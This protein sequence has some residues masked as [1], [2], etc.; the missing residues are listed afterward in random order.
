MSVRARLKLPWSSPLLF[1]VIGHHSLSG[2]DTVEDSA[3]PLES[4]SC[5]DAEQDVPREFWP[6][7]RQQFSGVSGWTQLGVGC[8]DTA[9]VQKKFKKRKENGV[10]AVHIAYRLIY[11]Q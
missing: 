9:K 10:V 3:F 7:L 11:V 4:I 6:S 1:F 8:A 5:I 2:F